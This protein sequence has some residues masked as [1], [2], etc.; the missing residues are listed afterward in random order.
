MGQ[1]TTHVLDTAAGCPAAGI[2]VELF[3]HTKS[4]PD[5]LAEARTNADG[6]L[7]WPI[8]EGAEYKSGTYELVFHVGAYFKKTQTGGELFLDTVPVRFVLDEN[9]DHYHVPLL[10]SP[11]SYTTYRGS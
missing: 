6:R 2:H 9:E 11:F 7:G 10:I 5:K 8:L 1:L 4:G 3:R